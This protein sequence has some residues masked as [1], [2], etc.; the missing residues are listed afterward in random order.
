MR[1][2]LVPFALMGLC[3]LPLVACEVEGETDATTE[4]TGTT[5]TGGDTVIPET[6]FYSVIVDDSVQFP[7]HRTG[8]PCATSASNAHGADIDAMELIDTDGSTVLGTLSHTFYSEGDFCDDTAF[9]DPSEAEGTPDGELDSGFVSLAGGSLTGEFGA[10]SL[11]LLEGYSI[12]VYEID[13]A[14]CAGIPSCVG[15]EK[16]SVYISTDLECTKDTASCTT[17]L[18]ADNADGSGTFEIPAL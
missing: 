14:F 13:D 1:K 11:E 6:K 18:I 7:D 3:S 10:S 16:Y 12:Q 4:P 17:E 15:S 5:D 9:T 2:I 8:D